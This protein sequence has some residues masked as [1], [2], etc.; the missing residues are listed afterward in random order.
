MAVE[1]LYGSCFQSREDKFKGSTVFCIGTLS[2]L[3]PQKCHSY[4]GWVQHEKSL[5]VLRC[6]V[7]LQFSFWVM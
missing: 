2:L 6:A 1:K 4:K 5:G 3:A 7:P